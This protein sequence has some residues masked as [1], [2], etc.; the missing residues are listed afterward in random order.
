MKYRILGGTGLK[1]SEIG[2]GAWGIGGSMWGSTDDTESLRAVRKALLVGINYFDTAYVYGNGHS[3]TLI[4]QALKETGA[5][6]VVATKAPPQNM[7]WPARRTTALLTAFPPAWIVSCTERSLRN[8]RTDS[9]DLQQFHV[10]YDSWLRDP[11]WEGEVMPCLSR[12]KEQG[13]IRFFGISVN[14]DDPHSA[15]EAVRSGAVDSVQVIFNL[16]DQR[17]AETF[18]PLCREKHAGVVVRC[19]FDEGGLTGKL[20]L[21]TRFEPEDFRS[22]YFGGTRLAETV[23]RAEELRAALA[24]GGGAPGVSLADA[25]LRFVLSFDAVSTVIPGM[26]SAHHVEE[27]ARASGRDPFDPETLR[28]LKAHAWVRHFYD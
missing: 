10:W 27:N 3:E 5:K 11:A 9:L 24:N 26:R 17:P 21:R 23:R 19:P 22:H 28:K 16:F 14:S 18:L 4:A 6:A 2:F 8:L 13:K 20:S 12:L 7:E 25:A 1:V 15:L